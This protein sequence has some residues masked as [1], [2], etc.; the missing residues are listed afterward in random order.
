M[1]TIKLETTENEKYT[2]LSIKL[3]EDPIA[4]V[5]LKDIKIPQLDYKK[6]VVI[7][8]RAPIWLYAFLVHECHPAAWVATQDP[9]LGGVVI[10][11]HTRGVKVADIIE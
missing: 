5:D 10:A 6:G 4:P 11:T 8:G 1:T 2:L 7:G 9:R 3:P